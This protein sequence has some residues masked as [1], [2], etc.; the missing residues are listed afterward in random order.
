MA[1]TNTTREAKLTEVFEAITQG[2]KQIQASNDAKNFLEGFIILCQKKSASFA[3]EIIISRGE[4][5]LDALR[6]AVRSSL[7]HAFLSSSTLPFIAELAAPDVESLSSGDFLRRIILEIVCPPTF[8]NGLVSTHAVGQLSETSIETFA[9]LCLQVLNIRRDNGELSHHIDD[10]ESIVINR[11]FD[12]AASHKTR[13]YHCRIKKILAS[14]RSNSPAQGPKGSTPGGRHDNDFADFREIS[15]LPTNDELLSKERPFLP[16]LEDVFQSPHVCS[17]MYLDWMF[18]LLREEMLAELRDD[19]K[20]ARSDKKNRK[21]L[22]LTDLYYVGYSSG[23]QGRAKP[24]SSLCSIF[25]SSEG[26]LKFLADMGSSKAQTYL[27]ENKR[28]LRHQSLAVLYRGTDVV[29]FGSLIRQEGELSKNPPILTIQFEEATAFKKSMQYLMGPERSELRLIF[30]NTPMFAF[31]PILKRLQQMRELRLDTHL[32]NPKDAGITLELPAKLQEYITQWKCALESGKSVKIP[33]R[34]TKKPI[35]VC[36]AQLE[37]LINGLTNPVALIQGPPGTG[38]SFIGALIALILLENTDFKILLLSYTNHAVDQFLEDLFEIGVESDKIVRLGSRNSPATEQVKL[39]EYLKD[40]KYLKT[41]AEW[42]I[43]NDLNR[44]LS[45][46]REKIA[47]AAETLQRRPTPQEIIDYLEFSELSDDS[48]LWEAFQ[49]PEEEDGFVMAMGN[50][51]VMTPER[52][53]STWRNDISS[54]NYASLMKTMSCRAGSVWGLSHEKRCQLHARWEH[55]VRDEQ[56]TTIFELAK[57]Q[58]ELYRQTMNVLNESKRRVL[59]E[60]RVIACTT[61]AAAKYESIIG[62]AKP[63]VVILEESGQILEAHTVTAFGATTQQAILIGDHR[64]LPPKVN[65]YALTKEKGDGYDLNVSMFERLIR[66]G[67]DFTTLSRQHRS[68]PDIS[69]FAKMLAYESLEDVEQTRAREQIRGLETRVAY[70]HHEQPEDAVKGALDR[71][72]PTSKATKAN[73]FEA[74]MVLKM[75]KYLGQ[76]G[77]GTENMVILTPYLGQLYLLREFLKKDNDPCLNDLDSGELVRA[78]LMTSAAAQLKK[79]TIRLATIGMCYFVSQ[80]PK[81]Y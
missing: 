75:V 49:V 25:V 27:K 35:E 36:D 39:D 44:E 73:T 69:S 79:K 74:Q 6:S 42:E 40:R 55:C 64:Q 41:T 38:K 33:T 8:W 50:Q 70:V 4:T 9:W 43:I 47:D 67:H 62:A 48:G 76:Q 80:L 45:E 15:L 20:L 52:L 28:F 30:V 37:S 18:R 63:D 1:P 24:R 5:A 72:D 61:T 31:E 56:I 32:L 10:I 66:H 57:Q 81:L 46:L 23:T 58:N 19:L 78:G 22:I 54:R 77:Y 2:K 14:L 68:H 11:S 60:K 29:S 59:S 26:G 16:R 3:V 34:S 21:P 51:K 7:S 17:E 13:V 12:R 71:Q 53:Y 65:N